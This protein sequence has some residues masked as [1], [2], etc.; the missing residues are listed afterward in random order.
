MHKKCFKSAKKV[1]REY[2]EN[3]EKVHKKYTKS[4]NLARGQRENSERKF[5]R[6]PRELRELQENSKKIIYNR[7]RNN[8]KKVSIRLEVA[9]NN[10]GTTATTFLSCQ[11][12]SPRG[13]RKSFY[14]SIDTEASRLLY[15]DKSLYKQICIFLNLYV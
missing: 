9:T 14:S 10:E 12:I 6:T 7:C 2:Q 8:V 3:I 11:K 13:G 15:S 5:R 4:V 1:P